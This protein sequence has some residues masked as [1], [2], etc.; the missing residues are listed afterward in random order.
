[1]ITE[2]VFGLFKLSGIHKLVR[3]PNTVDNIF[4]FIFT[5]TLTIIFVALC[6]FTL[7]ACLPAKR[8]SHSWQRDKTVCLLLGDAL[9][10]SR[11]LER[12]VSLLTHIMVS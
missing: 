2:C 3:F 9:V 10:Y 8:S 4:F 12:N 1:M 6:V 11:H 5:V 7:T